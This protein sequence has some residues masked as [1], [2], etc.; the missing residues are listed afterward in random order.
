MPA[1]HA[2]LFALTTDQIDMVFPLARE[3]DSQL[4]L[5][6]WRKFAEPRVVNDP[7]ER[8]LS[9][10]LLAS[11]NSHIRGL[12]AYDV[13]EAI[14]PDRVLKASHVVI[15][16]RTRERHL[17]MDL[18]GG[19][20][21]IAETA[22]CMRVCAELPSSSRWLHTRWSDPGGRVFRLP[23]ECFALPDTEKHPP[24]TDVVNF[25]PRN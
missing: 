21:R 15:V 2:D 24:A 10:V 8:R 1:T 16:D 22:E 7:S 14:G 5:D 3:A 6:R 20:L 11:R 12:A 18:L 19:L 9:G 4:S 23:V 17:E 13:S 25:R